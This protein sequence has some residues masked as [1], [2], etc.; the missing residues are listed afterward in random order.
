MVARQLRKITVAA[1]VLAVLAGGSGP[2]S[3]C[4]F[5]KSAT[6]AYYAPAPVVAPACT[7]CNYVPQVAYRTVYTSVPVT[8]YR[9]ITTVNP[10]TGCPVTALQPVTAYRLQPQLVPYTTY[11]PVM[12]SCCG[13][14]TTVGYAPAPACTTGACGA[15]VPAATTYYA[16]AVAAPVMA[17]PAIPAAPAAPCCGNAS[18]TLAPM[19]T[20][21]YAMTPAPTYSATPSYSSAGSTTYTSP[22]TPSSGPATSQ[23]TL[24]PAGLVGLRFVVAL[25]D[26]PPRL[27]AERFVDSVAEPETDSRSGN[28]VRSAAFEHGHSPQG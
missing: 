8:S 7:T 14:P 26:L 6:T 19:A 28:L 13:A 11:R 15:A 16:P 22:A 25:L 4:C 18:S 20:A 5:W 27:I 24:P 2:A 9:P 12:T 23:P 10:C 21:S 1:S 3:A 17:A